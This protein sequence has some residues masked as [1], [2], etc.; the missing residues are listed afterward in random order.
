MILG[1]LAPISEWKRWIV[2]GM[3]VM[4]E[5]VPRLNIPFSRPSPSREIE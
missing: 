2:A 3:P 1:Y 5:S 4:D